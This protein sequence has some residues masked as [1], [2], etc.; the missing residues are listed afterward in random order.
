MPCEKFDPSC[1]DCRPV[2][3]D[4]K[5]GRPLPK[6]DPAA[7]AMDRAWDAAPY[8]QQEAFWLCTVRSSKDPR[9]LELVRQLMLKASARSS[10]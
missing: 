8:E 3:L 10:N 2:L 7:A 1:P 6:S 4:V 9:L 5:T